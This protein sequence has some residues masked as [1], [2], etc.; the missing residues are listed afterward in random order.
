MCVA[1]RFAAMYFG[2]ATLRAARVRMD[3][4][5]VTLM[6]RETPVRDAVCVICGTKCWAVGESG[7]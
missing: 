3:C 5:T 6:S 7:W 4:E 1:Y 2:G